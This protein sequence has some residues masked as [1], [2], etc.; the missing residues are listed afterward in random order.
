MQVE[1]PAEHLSGQ[2]DAEDGKSRGRREARSY[3]TVIVDTR[4]K[5]NAV[6]PRARAS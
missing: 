1:H 5:V 3:P 2:D 4:M 6:A